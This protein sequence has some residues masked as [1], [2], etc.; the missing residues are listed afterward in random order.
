M[1]VLIVEDDKFINKLTAKRLEDTKYSVLF[2]KTEVE[3]RIAMVTDNYDA[4]ICDGN[5]PVDDIT[6]VCENYKRTLMFAKKHG[7]THRIISSGSY[8]LMDKAITTGH[9]TGKCEKSN[10]AAKL[11]EIHDDAN[12]PNASSK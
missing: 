1:R 7:I 4:I 12:I 9:A 8:T 6:P 11:K 2:C 10:I 5:F 3:A